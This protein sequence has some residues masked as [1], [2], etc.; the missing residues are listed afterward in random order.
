MSNIDVLKYWY[1]LRAL[2]VPDPLSPSNLDT[3]LTSLK[4]LM[5]LDS[6]SGKL[7]IKRKLRGLLRNLL[8]VARMPC[9]LRISLPIG[10]LFKRLYM[11]TAAL[12][13]QSGGNPMIKRKSLKR[14]LCF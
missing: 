8:Y 2:I 10:P 9:N 7:I 3:S 6:I 12:L 11:N 5:I 4:I 13:T 14:I 1:I